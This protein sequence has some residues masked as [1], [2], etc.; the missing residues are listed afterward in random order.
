MKTSILI[1]VFNKLNFTLSCLKDL[2]PLDREEVEVI[3]INNASTDGTKEKLEQVQEHMDNIVLINNDENLGFGKALNKGY[4]RAKGENVIF[5]NNDIRVSS[6]KEVWINFL[7]RECA[8]N[9]LVGASA[10]FI[11]PKDNF[12]FKWETKDPVKFQSANYLSGWCIAALKS[13]FDKLILATNE[14]KGPWNEAFFAYYEDPDLCFRAKKMGFVSKIVNIPVSHFGAIT[15]KELNR[16]H[17]YDQSR[18]IFAK[19]WQSAPPVLQ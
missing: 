11:D 18:Q 7:T 3:V 9:T 4:E 8:L 5:L 13:E 19:R 16:T 10:G 12:H 6:H 15:S 14:F 17:L 2:K 1:P